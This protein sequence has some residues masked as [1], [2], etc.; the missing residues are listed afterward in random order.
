IGENN[1]DD[2]SPLT[3]LTNLELLNASYNQ[4]EDVTLIN[5]LKQLI[6]LDL[7]NNLIKFNSF[8]LFNANMGEENFSTMSIS[9]PFSKLKKLKVLD[10]SNNQITDISNLSE[11]TNI[12]ELKL[13]ENKIQDI[14][15]LNQLTN[16]TALG[17]PYNEI[18]NINSLS[19]LTK[20]K[21]L[22]LSYN[23]I[24]DLS[25]L[26]NLINLSELA[27]YNNNI[28]DVNPLSNLINLNTLF[29]SDNNIKLSQPLSYLTNLKILHI[30]DNPISDS[31]ALD[32][33]TQLHELYT[34]DKY[35]SIKE[36]GEKIEAL[37]DKE[38]IIRVN[39]EIDPLTL[40]KK[41]IYVI[42]ENGLHEKVELK[43]GDDN[44][45]IHVVPPAG[46]YKRGKTY[47]LYITKQVKSVSGKDLKE[48]IKMKFSIELQEFASDLMKIN[49]LSSISSINNY[50]N[51]SLQIK[52]WVQFFDSS[53]TLLEKNESENHF[54]N[55]IYQLPNNDTYKMLM[56]S[57]WKKYIFWA[58]TSINDYYDDYGK[59]PHNE[60]TMREF[61]K[62]LRSNEKTIAEEYNIPDYS[63]ETYLSDLNKLVE[64][65]IM[66]VHVHPYM[67][68]ILSIDDYIKSWKEANE[69]STLKS[70][71]LDNELNKT[72]LFSSTY[73][74]KKDTTTQ[75]SLSAK[76]SILKKERSYWFDDRETKAM[77]VTK[78]Y[79]SHWLSD[80]KEIATVY[81]GKV[82]ARN[83][84]NTVIKVRY[85][86]KPEKIKIEVK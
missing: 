34:D 18:S 21:Y 72:G 47:E 2:L 77:T 69:K 44:R 70:I 58:S 1:I 75:L 23:Q 64:S 38:W 65:A 9:N 50:V 45:S 3:N 37:A 73:K 20:L 31:Q 86:G 12:E 59:V 26:S 16:L 30:S 19:E 46:G 33:L 48:P 22:D 13:S 28:Y 63:F 54:Y 55:Y 57:L 52:G 43:L 81:K 62:Q 85:F 74:M 24:D 79:D 25:S 41:N 68:E 6:E 78:L 11:L 7:S 60:W 29:L 42:N 71:Q 83:K 67:G 10:L 53:L 27:L 40:T 82:Q 35:F 61:I 17:I 84:G 49:T 80:N 36:W 4:I 56:N 5:L 32:K 14:S 8:S 15:A 51:N 39:H 66:T 76:Y